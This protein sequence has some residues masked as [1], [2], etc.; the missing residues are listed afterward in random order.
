M[1]ERN[2]KNGTSYPHAIEVVDSKTGQTRYIRSGSKIAFIEGSITETHSQGEYNR[3][4]SQMPSNDKNK[5]QRTDS[6]KRSRKNAKQKL[7]KTKSI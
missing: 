7:P 1:W 6:K 2:K 4:T 3:Q 5:L